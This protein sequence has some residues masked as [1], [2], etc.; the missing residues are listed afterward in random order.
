MNSKRKA[1]YLLLVFGSIL[2]LAAGWN[3][4]EDGTP[5]GRA[6]ARP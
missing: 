4:P 3:G 1:I 6:S 2:L 5:E